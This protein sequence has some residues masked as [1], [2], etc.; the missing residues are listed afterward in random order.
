[1]PFKSEAQRR[2]MFAKHPEIAKRWAKEYPN[3]K[4]LPEKVKSNVYQEA[5]NRTKA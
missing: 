2:F 3:Q 4:D 1:M 5:V